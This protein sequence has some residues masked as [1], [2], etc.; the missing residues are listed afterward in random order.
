MEA[1]FRSQFAGALWTVHVHQFVCFGG[2]VN[3]CLL[4]AVV[5]FFDACLIVVCWFV[6]VVVQ[7]HSVVSWL[8]CSDQFLDLSPGGVRA[9]WRPPLLLRRA[10]WRAGTL[11]LYI[12][13]GGCMEDLVYSQLHF[14]LLRQAARY[15]ATSRKWDITKKKITNNNNNKGA[16]ARQ[17]CRVPPRLGS[18]CSHLLFLRFCWRESAPW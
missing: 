9:S 2:V 1:I 6:L 18:P 12:Y 17:L 7:F 11:G 15:H 16:Q 3:F 4:F 8:R 5:F 10:S 14:C 13:C